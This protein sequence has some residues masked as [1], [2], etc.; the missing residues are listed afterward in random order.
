MN[1]FTLDKDEHKR[2]AERLRSETQKMADGA[3]LAVWM[4]V[5][6][7]KEG[8]FNIALKNRRDVPKPP[9]AVQVQFQM[10]REEYDGRKMVKVLSDLNTVMAANG[11]TMFLVCKYAYDKHLAANPPKPKEAE[12]SKAEP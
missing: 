10:Q 2:L 12:P 7:E 11:L 1:D 9:L 8:W 3:D 4:E 5:G 6:N